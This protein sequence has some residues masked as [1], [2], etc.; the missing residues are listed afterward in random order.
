[1]YKKKLKKKKRNEE[2]EKKKYL[3]KWAHR[4]IYTALPQSFFFILLLFIIFPPI[5]LIVHVFRFFLFCFNS[6]PSSFFPPF[7]FLIVFFF[8]FSYSSRSADGE[9]WASWR[10]LPTVADRQTSGIP[11]L[12]CRPFFFPPRS[13]HDLSQ[14]PNSG[15]SHRAARYRGCNS[16]FATRVPLFQPL[17]IGQPTGKIGPY[18]HRKKVYQSHHRDESCKIKKKKKKLVLPPFIFL[19][20]AF[21]TGPS[22]SCHCPFLWVCSVSRVEYRSTAR[23]ECTPTRARDSQSQERRMCV[24]NTSP[25]LLLML[26]ERPVI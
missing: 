16:A 15:N 1:M 9:E 18:G 5:S 20:Y 22:H 6:N 12:T 23:R 24:T 25:P 14:H 10:S 7:N 8:F 26:Y 3:G 21:T 11:N 4:Y 13:L 19:F 17:I 2:K